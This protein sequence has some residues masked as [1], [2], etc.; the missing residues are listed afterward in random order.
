MEIHDLMAWQRRLSRVS[1][2]R[3]KEEA[4]HAEEK[5]QEGKESPQICAADH[6]LCGDVPRRHLQGQQ[7][8]LHKDH[9]FQRHQLPARPERGQDGHLRELVRLF[10]LF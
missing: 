6:P 10:E 4:G 1:L 7:P 5:G 3:G 9:P 8:P 2:R